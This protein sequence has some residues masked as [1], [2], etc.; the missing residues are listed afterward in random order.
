MLFKTDDAAGQQWDVLIE[1]DILPFLPCCVHPTSETFDYDERLRWS[2][3]IAAWPEG[4][5]HA[6]AIEF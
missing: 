1:V 6:D 5:T 3:L 4:E 2:R